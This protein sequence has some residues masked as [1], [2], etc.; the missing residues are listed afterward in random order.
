MDLPQPPQDTELRNII[1]KL[2]QFVARNG[3]E[4]EQMTKN[5]QKGNPKFQFL[6]GGEYFNYYQYKVTTEQTDIYSILQPIIESCTK[7]SISN[8]KS[9]FLQHASNKE[10][11]YCIVHTLL[12][13]VIEAS[14][15]SQKLHVIYLVNDLLHHCA[16]KNANDLK[17]ALESVVVPMFCN[18]HISATEEQRAKLE[19]LLKLWESKAN[20]LDPNTVEKMRQPTQ[21]YQQYQSHQMMKY[22]AEIATLAQQTKATYDSYQAQHQAFVCHAMQ[23]IADLQQQKQA[24]EQQQQQQQPPPPIQNTNIIPLETIQAS[25]QQTIQS[26]SQQNNAAAQNQTNNQSFPIQTMNP[27]PNQQPSDFLPINPS[28]PP[29]NLTTHPPPPLGQ[30]PNSPSLVHLPSNGM[31]N[32]PFSQ[33]PPGFFRLLVFFPIFLNH[34]QDLFQIRNL[35]LLKN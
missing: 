1:D 4:F 16:R 35:Q 29:P 20:Y 5:K 18:A 10:K 13:K 11:A 6:Y 21:S 34:L 26:L 32:H 17:E 30:S 14:V 12:F 28:I 3:P 2:A 9:W 8:G 22:A 19:K 31:D 24:I 15:F 23:Q 25:L 33:P 7:D 27:P